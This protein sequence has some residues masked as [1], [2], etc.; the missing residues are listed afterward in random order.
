VS[1]AG[2]P[3]AGVDDLHKRLTGN[4]IGVRIP[5]EALRNSERIALEIEPSPRP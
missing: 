4:A 2:E 3:V 5:I 1:L